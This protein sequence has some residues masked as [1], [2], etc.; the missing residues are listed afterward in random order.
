[1]LS[2]KVLLDP[3]KQQ[4]LVK[5][6]AGSLTVDQNLDIVSLA[7]QMQSVTAGAVNFRTMPITGDAKDPQGRDILQLPGSST[8]HSF[9]AHLSDDAAATPATTAPPASAAPSTPTVAPSAVKVQVL[10]GSG[11]PGLA[12]K[13]AASLTSAGYTVVGTGNA[14]TSSYTQTQVR[15]GAGASAAAATLAAA[16]PGAA[17]AASSTAPAG[18]V[19]LVLGTDWSGLGGGSA[20]GSSGSAPAAAAGTEPARTAADTSCIN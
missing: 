10:N 17:T 8:L 4:Q 9:F 13:A 12:A 3:T 16:V 18:T 5:A 15:F 14:D 2:E 20:A 7:Q 6:V 19:Q 11:T 1:M